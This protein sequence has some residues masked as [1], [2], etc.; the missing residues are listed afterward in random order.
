MMDES[1]E[2]Y[3]FDSTTEPFTVPT[4]V[5]RRSNYAPKDVFTG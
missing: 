4:N 5:N 1:P 3:F 2:A